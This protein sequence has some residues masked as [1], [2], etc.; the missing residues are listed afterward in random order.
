[1]IYVDLWFTM[2]YLWWFSTRYFT[3]RNM[4]LFWRTHAHALQEQTLLPSF[5]MHSVL[6]ICKRQP[7]VEWLNPIVNGYH[8]CILYISIYIYIQYRQTSSG[9]FSKRWCPK[10]HFL[11]HFAK[12]MDLGIPHFNK[13]RVTALS[14]SQI[15]HDI[16]AVSTSAPDPTILR[17]LARA[18][19]VVWPSRLNEALDALPRSSKIHHRMS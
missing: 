10:T 2:I 11:E 6:G 13:P 1:M 12:P 4:L 18:K 17:P 14:S 15:S 3:T 7:F 8:I 19:G 9:G 5:P 16:S